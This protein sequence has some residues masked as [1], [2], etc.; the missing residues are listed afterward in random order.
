MFGI[1]LRKEPLKIDCS[2]ILWKIIQLDILNTLKGS[3]K[4]PANLSSTKT[5][6]RTPLAEFIKLFQVL[7]SQHKWYFSWH[8]NLLLRIIKTFKFFSSNRSKFP[9]RLTMFSPK[10]MA[11]AKAQTIRQ[12]KQTKPAKTSPPSIN[13]ASILV[14]A[15]VLCGV[16]IVLSAKNQL[17]GQE[18]GPRN[19]QCSASEFTCSNKRCVPLNKYCDSVNNCLDNSDE[20]RFCT[21]EL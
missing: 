2:K 13:A 7:N 14:V 3:S 17:P 15:L 20:P 1:M 5:L 11:A 8:K 12:T 18:Q 16:S 19:S 10:L 9:Q 6:C 4:L 21:S